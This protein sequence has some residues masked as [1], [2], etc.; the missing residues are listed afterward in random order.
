LI[1]EAEATEEPPWGFRHDAI[2]S[3]ALGK[4]E[5]GKRVR[6]VLTEQRVGTADEP[7]LRDVSE[8]LITVYGT[9]YG[10]VDLQVHRHDSPGRRLSR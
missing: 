10:H 1:A 8:A 2:G 6:V 9:D 7:T 4:L 3:H 5:E